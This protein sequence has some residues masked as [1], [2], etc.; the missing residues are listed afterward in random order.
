MQSISRQEFID[1]RCNS[2]LLFS[3]FDSLDED[4]RSVI[5]DSGELNAFSL[6][7]YNR[8]ACRL[9]VSR[10]IYSIIKELNN[11]T[12]ELDDWANSLNARIDECNIRPSELDIILLWDLP[13]YLSLPRF[14]LLCKLLHKYCSRPLKMHA[15]IYNTRYMPDEPQLYILHDDNKVSFRNIANSSM[16]CP[17]YSQTELQKQ[18]CPF[19]VEHVVILSSGIEEYLFTLD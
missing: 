3:I 7:F 6:D 2:P 15:Y 19:R 16:N 4:M 9:Y 13:N 10:L 1:G 18:S 14:E 5:L 8:Y 17:G 11:S 12:D